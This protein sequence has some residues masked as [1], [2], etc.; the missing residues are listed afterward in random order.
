MVNG[1]GTWCAFLSFFNSV[2]F[3]SSIILFYLFFH[4]TEVVIIGSIDLSSKIGVEHCKSTIIK[5]K[6][7]FEEVAILELGPGIDLRAYILL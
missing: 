5:I 1:S 2:K 6:K 3:S 4:L 7:Y